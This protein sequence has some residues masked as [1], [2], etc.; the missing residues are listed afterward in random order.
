MTNSLN[1]TPSYISIFTNLSM[2]TFTIENQKQQFAN[3]RI[4]FH[5]FDDSK[6]GI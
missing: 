3:T 6:A 4:Y 1:L 5:E 2:I